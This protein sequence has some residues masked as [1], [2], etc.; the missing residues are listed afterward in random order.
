MRRL[1]VALS[2][3]GLLAACDQ[4]PTP[5]PLPIPVPERPSV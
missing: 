5:Q 2:L 3:A 4:A 1:M